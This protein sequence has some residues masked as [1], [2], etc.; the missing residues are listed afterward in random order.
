MAA[1]GERPDS[2]R[3]VERM[4][5]RHGPALLRVAN[6]FSLCHDDALDAYQRA[7]EI[8]LRRLASVDPATEGAWLRV[9]VKH[10]AMAIRR[11]R[12]ASVDREDVDLDGSVPAGLREV[13]DTVAGGERVERSV[14]A[15]H[16]LKPDEARALLLK[17]EGL[18]Y[19]EIG[20]RFG[21]TY[22]KV[23]RSIT[24]GR[25]RFLK[26]YGGIEAGEACADHEE[27][28]GALAA[29]TATSA[30]VLAIRP[31]LR[32]CAACRATVREMRFSRARRLAL[33]GPFA[34]LT[35]LLTRPEVFAAS[36]SGGGRLGP[37]AAALGL[38]LSGVGAATCVV[39]GALPA[40]PIVAHADRKPEPAAKKK[41]PRHTAPK[42][43]PTATPT[44]RMTAVTVTPTATATRTPARPRTKPAT[45]KPRVRTTAKKKAREGEFGFE[46]SA[47]SAQ[48]A[49]TPAPVAHT[50]SVTTSSSSGAGSSGGGSAPPQRP[51]ASSGD[52][53]GFEGG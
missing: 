2:A 49:G 50:A 46:G 37:A 33:F 26:V 16:A 21:W 5:A 17:A 42:R 52:E 11:A 13:D 3:R 44:A 38:C 28:L 23:N 12:Q 40:P 9:V 51:A 45:T 47:P 41:P 4:V 8:Y 27:A 18:S 39:T 10:E 20:R 14:E 22:T 31:H 36:T 35:R 1:L 15:L 48:P 29:G 7:L 25:R 53:F 30:Q 43:T 24:E 32:H 6:Q 34:W 19:D